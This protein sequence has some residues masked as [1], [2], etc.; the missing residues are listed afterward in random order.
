MAAV[1]RLIVVSYRDDHDAQF[2]RL[3]AVLR[4]NHALRDENTELRRELEAR[5]APSIACWGCGR[6]N[7]SHIRYC[8]GCGRGLRSYLAWTDDVAFAGDLEPARSHGEI[9]FGIGLIS[10]PLIAA[11][12]YGLSTLF[13]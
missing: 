13:Y 6:E 4:E 5:I 12:V 11:L 2:A 3:E 1:L 10:L 7:A 9:A 8:L